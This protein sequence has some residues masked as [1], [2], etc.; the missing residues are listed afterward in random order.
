[1][2][3]EIGTALGT[4]TGIVGR[5]H[6]GRNVRLLPDLMTSAPCRLDGAVA[7]DTPSEATCWLVKSPIVF[8]LFCEWAFSLASKSQVRP[9]SY[10]EL[11]ELPRI[12]A[13]GPC[14]TP[15]RVIR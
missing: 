15:F 1:M 12:Y 14:P 8:L 5:S 3:D 13:K 4:H 10:S 6:G 7:D 2:A 11:A 9:K